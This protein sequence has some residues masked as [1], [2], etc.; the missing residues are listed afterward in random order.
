MPAVSLRG[1]RM[2]APL[3]ILALLATSALLPVASAIHED[4][5][6]IPLVTFGIRTCLFE[7]VVCVRTGYACAEGRC[8]E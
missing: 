5:V 2:R 4:G 3:L 7:D 1:A 8:D 6:P